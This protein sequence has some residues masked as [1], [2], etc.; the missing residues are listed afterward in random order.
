MNIPNNLVDHW[1]LS[2]AC[3]L[4]RGQPSACERD[5]VTLRI[6][7]RANL[8]SIHNLVC[9]AQAYGMI[10]AWCIERIFSFGVQADL[11]LG[12]GS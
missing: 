11:V 5:P 6:S 1:L 12:C 10:P 7:R 8:A 3:S 9:H 2:S 4:Y